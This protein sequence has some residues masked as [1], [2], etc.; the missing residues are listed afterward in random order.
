MLYAIVFTSA[1]CL[2]NCFTSV[3]EDAENI[4]LKRLNKLQQSPVQA[5]VSSSVQAPVSSTVKEPTVSFHSKT[6]DVKQPVVKAT[7]VT[8]IKKIIE[9]VPPP[10]KAGCMSCVPMCIRA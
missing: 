4:R 10:V 8:P 2:F 7:T 3:M 5:S 1:F 9:K 6:P